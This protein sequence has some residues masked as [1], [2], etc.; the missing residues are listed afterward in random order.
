MLESTRQRVEKDIMARQ[1]LDA[2]LVRQL[3]KLLDE[4]GLTELEYG[5]QTIKIRVARQPAPTFVTGGGGVAMG[6]A[7]AS[8]GAPASA[9]AARS[10]HPGTVH[11]PM[12]GTVYLA[13]EPSAP[14]FVKA[15][16]MVKA[17]QTLLI[18]EAMKVMNPLLAPRAGKVL[19]IIVRD[20]QPVEYGEPLLVIE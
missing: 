10:E 7:A 5:N 18:I 13:S 16:D 8:A 4:T 9:P 6:A 17:G 12:V 15:G 1:D 2:D 3:A 20:A 11:S 14:P 19:E